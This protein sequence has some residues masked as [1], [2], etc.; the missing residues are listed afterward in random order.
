MGNGTDNEGPDQRA[1]GTGG[2]GGL[3]ISS[4]LGLH[5]VLP[6]VVWIAAVSIE[7]QSEPSDETSTDHRFLPRLEIVVGPAELELRRVAGIVCTRR[8]RGGNVPTHTTEARSLRIPNVAVVVQSRPGTARLQTADRTS[9]LL[10][11]FPAAR[12]IDA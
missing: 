4:S 7:F 2:R 10:E 12:V 1:R 5:W 11:D 9:G 8:P 3:I 6:I